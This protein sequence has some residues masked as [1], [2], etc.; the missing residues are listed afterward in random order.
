MS[1]S[2]ETK[3]NLRLSTVNITNSI[4]REP[5]A[6]LSAAN[7][8]LSDTIISNLTTYENIFSTNNITMSLSAI[9]YNLMHQSIASADFLI[10]NSIILYGNIA[11]NGYFYTIGSSQ[12]SLINCSIDSLVNVS[13]YFT[14]SLTIIQSLN[15]N[16]LI[17]D[18]FQKPHYPKDYT[19]IIIVSVL[20]STS[21]ILS[22]V[23]IIVI[24]YSKRMKKLFI[25]QKKRTDMSISILSEFG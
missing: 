3:T 20:G 6:A 4:S 12:I 9:I 16:P 24:F 13:D 11:T 23:T 2:K 5:Y 7:L 1:F 21:L 17:I 19:I 25:S 10:F 18:C 8:I 14:N 15:I 22:I